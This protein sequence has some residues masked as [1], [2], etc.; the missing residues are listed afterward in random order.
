MTARGRTLTA[1]ELARLFKS[2]IHEPDFTID[3]GENFRVIQMAAKSGLVFEI[4]RNG[5]A[6]LLADAGAAEL[7]EISA[8][9]WAKYGSF[10]GPAADDLDFLT[11]DELK[12][13]PD[14]A[15]GTIDELVPDELRD[16]NEMKEKKHAASR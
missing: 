8:I 11:P 15:E 1:G 6:H 13:K 7:A 3:L 10:I 9:L 5:K 12:E 2:Q 16:V 4:E 14:E